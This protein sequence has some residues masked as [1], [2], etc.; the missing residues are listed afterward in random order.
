MSVK[1]AKIQESYIAQGL[2]EWLVS[3]F[4]FTHIFAQIWTHIYLEIHF[5]RAKSVGI[6]AECRNCFR[7]NYIKFIVM[8]HR[9]PESCSIPCIVLYRI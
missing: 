9:K 3:I 8:K 7:E 4:V 2:T 6:A 1:Y 5:V